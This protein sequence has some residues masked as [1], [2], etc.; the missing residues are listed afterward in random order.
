M[1]TKCNT[2]KLLLYCSSKPK[3]AE[4]MLLSQLKTKRHK[5]HKVQKDSIFME[6]TSFQIITKYHDLFLPDIQ[7]SIHP[8]SDK[9][10]Q[11]RGYQGFGYSRLL[12]WVENLIE[13]PCYPTP[14]ELNF[15]KNRR[16]RT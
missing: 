3:E 9:E 6:D 14:V 7:E 2:I 1:I 13:T 4:Y 15:N 11:R 10:K 8:K 12:S 5:H 16:K